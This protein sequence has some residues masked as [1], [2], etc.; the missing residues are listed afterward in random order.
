[1]M[2]EYNNY[3]IEINLQSPLATPLQS[4]TLFG[5][6][7]WAVRFLKWEKDDKLAEFLDCYEENVYPP[8]LISNGFPVGYLPKPVIPPVTQ[9]DLGK[10]FGKENRIENSYRIKTI[11]KTDI[12][13]KEKF[14]QLSR[15]VITPF[16]LFKAI[17]ESYD[18]IKQLKDRE[19]SVLIQHNTIDR[20]KGRVKEGGLYSNEETFFNNDSGKFEVYLRTNYFTIEELQRIFTFI[21][22]GG[23]GKDK[24]TGKGSFT[25]EIKNGFDLADSEKPNAFMILS[26]Y[27]PTEKDPTEGYYHILHKF[28][29]LGGLYAKGI[30]EINSN[31]FKVPLVMF[32]AGSVFFDKDYNHGKVYGSLLKDVHQ[33]KKIRHYA[34]AF[35]LGINLEVNDE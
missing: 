29:K 31:P 6:I 12:I 4:D 32:S 21:G 28:G 27:I 7:C 3:I 20:I 24:S 19:Q 34:Y 9:K 17:D 22:T 10:I 25:F 14:K 13:P 33:N 15:E 23:F 2:R 16:N 30:S 5:H 11:K 26:S 35:P 1:M 18:D 8:L